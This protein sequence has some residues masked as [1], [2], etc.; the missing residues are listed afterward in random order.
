MTVD[1]LAPYHGNKNDYFLIS[2]N[3]SNTEKY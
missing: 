1:Y 2:E 3:E